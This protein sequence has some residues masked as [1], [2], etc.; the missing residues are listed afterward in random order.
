MEHGLYVLRARPSTA[1]PRLGRGRGGRFPLAARLL[2][3]GLL[4]R[5]ARPV[6]LPA[7]QGRQPPR[8]AARPLG[9]WRRMSRILRAEPLTACRLRPLRRR[10]GGRGRAGPD[11]QPGALRALAR[12]R[13]AGFRARDRS[14]PAAPACRSSSPSRARCPTGWRWSSA[15]PRAAR[16]SCRCTRTPFWSSSPRMKAAARHPARL[17]H[18]R[19]A[20]D[21]LPPRHLARRAHPAARARPLRRD[22]PDRCHAEPAGALV[23]PA[24]GGAG[25]AASPSAA[26]RPGAALAN[27]LQRP[28]REQSPAGTDILRHPPVATVQTVEIRLRFFPLPSDYKALTRLLNL[29]SPPFHPARARLSARDQSPGPPAARSVP[30]PR[31]GSS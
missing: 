16:P 31:P 9:A 13:A 24:V 22:R 1:Q 2:P 8:A 18:R 14:A 26:N 7:L 17:P 19:R 23:R 21:Q 29:S 30:A 4:R 28:C 6:P 15:T 25:L 12:P 27:R 3:A 10:A 5:R 20:G 11:H